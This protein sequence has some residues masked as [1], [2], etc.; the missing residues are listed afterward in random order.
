VST[1]VHLPDSP[2]VGVLPNE[3]SSP[4]EAKKQRIE[5][6]K[7]YGGLLEF[8]KNT[9]KK[10]EEE[11]SQARKD[12]LI[13]QNKC[14]AIYDGRHYIDLDEK[15]G[16]WKDRKADSSEFRPQD[17]RYKEQVDKLQMEMARTSIELACEPV[18]KTDSV[19][20][21]AAEFAKSRIEANRK[22]LFIQRPEFVLTE[23]MSLLLKTI[24]Y[25]Y[26]YFD[27]SD[28]PKEKRPKF[29]K[30]AVGEDKS[31]TVCAVC[32]APRDV[33]NVPSVNDEK[34]L[35]EPGQPNEELPPTLPPCPNCG[36]IS[37]KMLS[38]SAVELELPAG[39]EEVSSGLVRSVHADPT[40]VQVSL[41]ARNMDI[42]T[43]P[44]L[45]WTQM[46]E[47]GKLERMFPD[48]V[49]PS[50]DN[51]GDDSRYRRENET[52]VSNS[53]N[54]SSDEIEKGGEQLEKLKFK[55]VWLD[56]WV[57]GDYVSQRPERLPGGQELPAGT[58]LIELFPDGM[59]VAKVGDTPLALYSEDKNK[60][61]SVCVYGLRESAWHGSGTNA[62]IPIQYTINDLLA[63]R[64]ANV[65]YNTFTR[66]FIKQGALTGDALPGLT[67]VAVV[68][69]VDE[70]QKIVGNAYDRAPG[71]PLPAEVA[72][73]AQEQTGALQEQ[74]GTSS[75]SLAGTSAQRDALGTATGIAAMRDLAVGRMGPN[76]M[77]KAA[78][79]VETAY[80]IL[81]LEQANYSKQ[82]LLAFAGIKP[83]SVGNLG[84]SQ[85]GVEA[86]INC[87][88]R[89]SFNITPIP[90]SWMPQTSQEQKADAIAFADAASKVQN[91]EVLANL[92]RVFKQPMSIEGFN[93]TQREAA[94][95]IEEFSK[96]VTLLESR[97]YGEPTDEMA[98]AVLASAPDAQLN[99]EMDNHPAFIDFHKDWW[100]SDEARNASPLLK[101]VI[102]VRTREHKEAMV[103]GT[104]TEKVNTLRTQLPD[105]AASQVVNESQA[106]QEMAQQGQ[107]AEQ[108]LALQDAQHEQ[109]Q[110]HAIDDAL[111][112]HA[113]RQM[114]VLPTQNQT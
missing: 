18:D 61:W 28:G 77:L 88:I 50:S 68:S 75:L 92:A 63:Y 90:G 79:E 29:A 64:V 49:I 113:G 45:I 19:M 114:G 74:A 93:A 107:Q 112:E 51:T 55:L 105:L 1:Q 36:S 40:M 106:Q 91:P 99:V 4:D 103:R 84:F 44:Y 2:Q 46:V 95:R 25:R 27:K 72:N 101:K 108:Q 83:G 67:T 26:T 37:T 3:N 57:Y 14:Q 73:L 52:A 35:V 8:I 110:E 81:E 17:N 24:T 39:E 43:T 53:G 100:P 62:L 9:C 85:R 80:Q 65:Y 13:Q 15:T 41:N 87:D 59:C 78:L 89:A 97:G 33:E 56:S 111:I 58:K 16:E 42:H 109:E 10:V 76:L 5:R 66:E 102:E 69:N 20:G 86:F 48:R 104:Q 22:R 60:K 96:V 7:S 54:F 94:R 21:E 30:K 38:T 70:N 82:R 71:N 47:R 12:I 11:D 32:K 6:Q 23:N 31:L 34:Y 98:R